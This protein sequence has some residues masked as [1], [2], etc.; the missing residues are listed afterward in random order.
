MSILHRDGCEVAARERVYDAL[1]A[2]PWTTQE[3]VGAAAITARLPFEYEV[4]RGRPTCCGGPYLGARVQHHASTLA[5][6]IGWCLLGATLFGAFGAVMEV[7]G[8]LMGDEVVGDSAF[9]GVYW[10]TVFTLGAL[11]AGIVCVPVLLYATWGVVRFHA[12]PWSV[13]RLRQTWWFPMRWR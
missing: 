10:R 7:L 11:V 9:S 12:L 5:M 6:V 1:G 3:T 13:R 8:L 2:L 4:K